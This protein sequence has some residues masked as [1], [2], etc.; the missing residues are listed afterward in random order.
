MCIKGV[1]GNPKEWQRE[2]HARGRVFLKQTQLQDTRPGKK[3][4][5]TIL[6]YVRAQSVVLHRDQY[7]GIMG[8]SQ[9]GGWDSSMSCIYRAGLP[10]R[11]WPT[12]SITKIAWIGKGDV[13]AAAA[14]YLRSVLRVK[15]ISRAPSHAKQY[16]LTEAG[17]DVGG[18]GH[19][20]LFT[21]TVARLLLSQLETY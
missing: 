11:A 4:V 16:L 19:W 1:N 20:E 5:D 21:S 14:R 6:P 17:A 2:R 18:G 15:A 13:D 10:H 8:L 7:F 12:S 9:T 3:T